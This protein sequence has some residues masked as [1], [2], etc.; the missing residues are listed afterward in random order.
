L[1]Q[2]GA[3]R[4]RGPFPSNRPISKGKRTMRP[5]MSQPKFIDIDGKRYLWRYLLQ[6]RREQLKACA[7]RR[8]AAAFELRLDRRPEQ[9]RAPAP[10]A[11]RS[12]PSRCRNGLYLK[13]VGVLRCRDARR[14]DLHIP[15]G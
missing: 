11:I 12:R 7:L 2:S 1:K 13:K 10:D 14:L 15:G 5:A 4:Q 3:V 6:L 9:Q 8:A